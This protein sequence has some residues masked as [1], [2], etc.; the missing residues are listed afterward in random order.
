MTMT[1]DQVA[2][3]LAFCAVFDQRKGDDLDVKAWQLIAN[4]HRWTPAAA[5]R[6][7]REHY[8]SGS[9]RPRIDPAMITDRIRKLRNQAAESFEAPVIPESLSG[10]DYPAWL[11]TQLGE[12]VDTQLERWATTGQEPDRAQPA[13]TGHRSLAE[14]IAT[15]PP[16]VRAELEASNARINRR[17]AR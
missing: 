10:R 6:I 1:Y 11:R 15:A 8:G 12:H 13:I 17:E 2:E 7:A 5:M 4:D 3:L 16:H 9:D 14:V